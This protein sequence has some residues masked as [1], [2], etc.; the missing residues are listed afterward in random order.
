VV[1][2]DVNG[3]G[4]LLEYVL[5][6]AQNYALVAFRRHTNRTPDQVN[7]DVI[8]GEFKNV[9]GVPLPMSIVARIFGPDGKV[10]Y[11]WKAT[12]KEYRVSDPANTVANLQIAW[13]KGA[14]VPDVR[15]GI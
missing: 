4:Q 7:N 14:T 2:Q 11:Q 5:D 1:I 12:I 6:P 9:K 3:H 10:I 8:A 15:K 13:P